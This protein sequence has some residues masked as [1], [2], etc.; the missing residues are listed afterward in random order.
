LR[1]NKNINN[2]KR[3]CLMLSETTYKLINHTDTNDINIAIS[4]LNIYNW[5]K[6]NGLLKEDNNESS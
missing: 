2:I 4:L 6:Q 1:D 5:K 3:C